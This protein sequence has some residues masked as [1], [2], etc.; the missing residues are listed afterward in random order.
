MM[1]FLQEM[2]SCNCLPAVSDSPTSATISQN[3]YMVNKE[4]YLGIGNMFCGNR[5]SICKLSKLIRR[6]DTSG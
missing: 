4:I 6:E 1:L 2:F 3:K 5:D